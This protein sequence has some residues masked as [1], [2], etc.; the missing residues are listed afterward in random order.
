MATDA[1]MFFERYQGGLLPSES[2]VDLGTEDKGELADDFIK[3]QCKNGDPTTG[4]LFEVEDYSFDIEQVLNIGSQSTGAG[5]G[6]VTFN[7]FSITRKI[8][9]A[10]PEFFQMACSGTPFKQVG[11]GLRKSSGGSAAGKFF[12]NFRFS[13]VAVKTLSWAH[14]EESP[15]ETIT[16]EYGALLVNYGRQGAD[17]QIKQILGRGWDRT[18]NKADNNVPKIEAK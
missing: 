16:F 5:A 7:A 4:K 18:K 9:I 2:T 12:V 6:R 10:S 11:L 13:L 1:Y 14:D 3:N 17:G 8:D 15:K